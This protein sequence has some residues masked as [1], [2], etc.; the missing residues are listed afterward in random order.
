MC[1]DCLGPRRHN[2]T[3][4]AVIFQ[5]HDPTF[6]INMTP[7]S[8]AYPRINTTTSFGSVIDLFRQPSLERGVSRAAE[9]ILNLVEIGE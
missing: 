6:F 8:K 1:D 3:M 2:G 4:M 9:D 7:G 5:D